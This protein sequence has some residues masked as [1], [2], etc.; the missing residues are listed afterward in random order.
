MATRR[1][2]S[3]ISLP[4]LQTS[5]SIQSKELHCLPQGYYVILQAGFGRLSKV[6]GLAWWTAESHICPPFPEQTVSGKIPAS[7]RADHKLGNRREISVSRESTKVVKASADAGRAL[8]S[9]ASAATRGRRKCAA[10][11][12]FFSDSSHG[13]LLGDSDAKSRPP[14]CGEWLQRGLDGSVGSKGRLLTPAVSNRDCQC[15]CL[16][17]AAENWYMFFVGLLLS[18]ECV[19]GPE[20]KLTELSK[21]LWSLGLG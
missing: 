19:S 10:F 20:V 9:T 2:A 14:P 6:N 13:L 16:K 3:A 1:R 15:H 8:G 7:P 17:I 12:F 18:C 11:A 4:N 5:T 21:E